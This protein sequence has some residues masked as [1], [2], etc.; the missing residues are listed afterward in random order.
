MSLDLWLQTSG[1]RNLKKSD[2]LKMTS[3]THDEKLLSTKVNITG[4]FKI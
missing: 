2:V 1:L 4:N 3:Y